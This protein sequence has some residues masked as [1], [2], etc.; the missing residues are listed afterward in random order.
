MMQTIKI[1]GIMNWSFCKKT[2]II[3][4]LPTILWHGEKHLL[5]FGWLKYSLVIQLN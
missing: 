4:I 5:E 3:K 1:G 2:G